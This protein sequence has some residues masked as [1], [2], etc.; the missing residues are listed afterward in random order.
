MILVVKSRNDK[1]GP[2]DT[3]AATYL[4]LSTCPSTCPFRH[5]GCY[6]E[7]GVF[8]RRCADDVE[9][10]TEGMGL[11]AIIEHEAVEIEQAAANDPRVTGRP[12]RLHVSGDIR[13]V[14]HAIRLARAATAWK[15]ADGGPI[16]VYTHLWRSIPRKAWGPDIAS[17]ASVDNPG[18]AWDADREGYAPALVVPH[19]QGRKSW[20]ENGWKWIAC[21]AQ[22]SNTMCTSCRLCWKADRLRA[23][24]KGVVFEVHGPL[25][26]V[27]R[28]VI[29]T[30]ELLGI[31]LVLDLND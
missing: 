16:W 8:V 23:K 20:R 24:C 13:L 9:K 26:G 14:R 31:Q 17:L 28:A 1:I 10:Q 15:D 27:H 19:F 3:T 22:H 25:R 5:N 2:A 30:Q 18:Q 6:A 21:P 4:P 29:K 12:L 11:G 7:Y